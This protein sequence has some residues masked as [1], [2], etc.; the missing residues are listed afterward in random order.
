MSA[1]PL[2]VRWLVHEYRV[3]TAGQ[4]GNLLLVEAFSLILAIDKSGNY[5][6]YL[7][8]VLPCNTTALTRAL[9]R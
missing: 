3:D 6:H 1:V 5:V 2:N 7:I 4:A 8:L 9:T